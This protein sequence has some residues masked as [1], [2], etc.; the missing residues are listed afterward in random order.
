[1]LQ[2]LSNFMEIKSSNSINFVLN[3]KEIEAREDGLHKFLKIFLFRCEEEKYEENR[4]IF[5]SGY[6]V[7]RWCNQHQIWY[8]GEVYVEHK[9]CDWLSKNPP[10]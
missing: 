10:C 8:E 7:N 3:L 9:I 4:A 2:I 1:M 6:L 5:K